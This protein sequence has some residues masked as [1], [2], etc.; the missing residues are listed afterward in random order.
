MTDNLEGKTVFV[1]GASSGLGAHFATVCCEAGAN[2]IIASRRA[3]VLEALAEKLRSK[4]RGKVQTVQ[5]DVTD[6]ASVAAAFGAVTASMS[7][8]ITPVWS[9]VLPPSDRLKLIGMR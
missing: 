9:T 8:S 1:T 4:G 6:C 3:Q 2:L 7:S 5:L